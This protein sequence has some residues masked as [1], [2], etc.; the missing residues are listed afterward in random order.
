MICAAVAAFGNAREGGMP[1]ILPLMPM[2]ELPAEQSPFVYPGL[3]IE[4]LQGSMMDLRRGIDFRQEQRVTACQGRGG[5]ERGDIVD[6]N[7]DAGISIR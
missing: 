7:A 3:R 4:G 2:G 5:K 6:H 1:F